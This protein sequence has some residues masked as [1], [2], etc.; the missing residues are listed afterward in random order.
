M[1]FKQAAKDIP[2]QKKYL[3]TLNQTQAKRAIVAQHGEEKDPERSHCVFPLPK[4]A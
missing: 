3:S 1:I 2:V 4:G